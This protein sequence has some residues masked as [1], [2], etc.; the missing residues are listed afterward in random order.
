VAGAVTI[1]V[2]IVRLLRAADELDAHGEHHS[3]DAVRIAADK[4]GSV[5]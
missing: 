4:L 3:A 1:K 2:L 5:R